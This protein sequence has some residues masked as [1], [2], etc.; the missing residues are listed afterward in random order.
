L[1]PHLFAFIASTRM[2]LLY[3]DFLLPKDSKP[4]GK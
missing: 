1:S 2:P 4:A 3:L